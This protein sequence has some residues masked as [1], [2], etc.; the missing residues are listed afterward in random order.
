MVTGHMTIDTETKKLMQLL[1]QVILADGHIHKTE[2]DALVRAASVLELKDMSAHLLTPE[3][4]R[5]WFDE[6][7]LELNETWS[8]APK[9]VTLTRLILSLADWPDKQAVV[10]A[11]QD[12]SLA[13][14][15]YH[16]NEKRL[17][18]I[19]KTFWQYDGLDAPGSTID[20]E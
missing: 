13:D 2:I 11:L 14:A 15:D 1:A 5:S 12:I 16:R 20:P 19:V 10:D 7:L 3:K 18:S 9:D 17:I 6:Y 8:T 4:I